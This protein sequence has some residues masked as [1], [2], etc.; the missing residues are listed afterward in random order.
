MLGFKVIVLWWQ[1]RQ[2]SGNFCPSNHCMCMKWCPGSEA[3][4]LLELLTAIT[5]T[6]RVVSPFLLLSKSPA[7]ASHWCNLNHFQNL[8]AWQSESFLAH[9]VR[10]QDKGHMWNRRR[11]E[12]LTQWSLRLDSGTNKR[13]A[14]GTGEI[15][16]DDQLWVVADQG[17]NRRKTYRRCNH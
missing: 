16:V 5:T 6:R 15:G 17:G 9:A 2:M 10:G 3:G 8:G 4:R 7:R 14:V 12:C 1:S 11:Q 13:T